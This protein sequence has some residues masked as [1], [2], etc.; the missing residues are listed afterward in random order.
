MR[1]YILKRIF[2]SVFVIVAAVVIVFVLLHLSGDPAQLMVAVDATPEEIE[3]VRKKMGFDQPVYVQLG[4]F[5]ARL[6]RGDMGDSLRFS[7]PVLP[8]VLER[9]PATIE[10]TMVAMFISVLL[11]VPAGVISA[12][13]RNSGLDHFVMSMTLVGQTVPVFW[14]GLML[15]LVFSVNLRWFPAFGRGGWDQL[16]LPAITLAAFSAARIARLVRSQMLDELGRDYIST[17]RAKGL[18]E[19]IV[20][21]FHALKNASSLAIT[22]IGLQMGHLLAGAVITETIFA[23]PGLG[24]LLVQSIHN[25]DYPMIQAAVLIVAVTFVVINLAVDILYTYLDPRIRYE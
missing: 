24:R 6:A 2:H 16:V 8:I 19:W 20:V 18:S 10:L 23:W 9:L 22:I 7:R 17:A 21:Y 11:A 12:T 1:T 13:R 14:L 3:A 25:R 5:A 4:R 15:V